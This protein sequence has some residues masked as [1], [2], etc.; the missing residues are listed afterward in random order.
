MRTRRVRWL[1]AAV[2]TSVVCTALQPAQ[3]HAAASP[4]PALIAFG[5]CDSAFTESVFTVRPD[6]T[7]LREVQTNASEP[8]WSPDGRRIL[9]TVHD[10]DGESVG[11]WTM[12]ADGSARRLIVERDNP[13]FETS[14]PG[15]VVLGVAF[16]TWSPD[17]RTIAFTAVIDDQ[18]GVGRWEIWSVGVDGTGLRRLGV[19]AKP[20]WSPD[21]RLIAFTTIG[22][23]FAPIGRI[24]VMAPDGSNVRTVIVPND[25]EG[26]R[27]SL[28]FS[29][30]SRRL[31]FVEVA[32]RTNVRTLDLRT[33][34]KTR[35]PESRTEQ[36]SATAWAPGGKRV[37]FVGN[38]VGP[39]VDPRWVDR[40][41][42]SKIRPDGSGLRRLFS[43]SRS[44]SSCGI[45]GG[46]SWR[47]RR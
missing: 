19:G 37:A 6:G 25:I 32:G 43:L 2:C 15:E 3:A 28:D 20:D 12:R 4:R 35:I 16:G 42:V 36:V 40:N 7:R 38:A 34:R 33:G 45:W 29:P 47:P 27:D 23:I 22:S 41:F 21:G 5:G 9:Y 14:G 17:G 31:A 8:E 11:L 18:T 24:A 1:L 46:L 44:Q 39:D 13:G 10:A 26:Y 30:D